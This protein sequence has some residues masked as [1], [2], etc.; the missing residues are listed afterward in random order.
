[1]Q[2]QSMHF[3]ARAGQRLADARLQKNL[4]K[5]SEKFVTAR[6]AAI[7]ELADFEGTRGSCCRTP[8][9]R[10]GAPGSVARDLR[11]QRARQGAQVLYAQSAQ[12]AA[13]L[14]VEIAQK[15][16]VRKVTKSKSMVSEEIQLN[17]AFRSAGSAGGDRPRRIHPAN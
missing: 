15:H 8:Q 11:A 17:A 6:A 9:S 10:A 5:L 16:G 12:D 13:R 2:T 1:M 4:K 3:K 14:I 7:S